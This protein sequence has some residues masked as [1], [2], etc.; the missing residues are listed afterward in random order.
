MT[1]LIVNTTTQIFNQTKSQTLKQQ[2]GKS[3]LKVHIQ[4]SK[5]YVKDKACYELIK[6]KL[7]DFSDEISDDDEIA[8]VKKNKEKEMSANDELSKPFKAASKCPFTK[9]NTQLHN[10]HT[11]ECHQMQKYTKERVTQRSYQSVADGNSQI[12]YANS[13]DNWDDL[14]EK[15]LNRFGMLKAC[16]KDPT[17]ITK[18][19][20]RANEALP[21]FRER[22][23]AV[24]GNDEASNTLTGEIPNVDCKSSVVQKPDGSWRMCID[25]KNLNSSCPKDYYPLPEIDSKIEAVM[26]YPL[27]CFLDA[28]KGYHQVQMSEE[29]EEKTAF[30]TDQDT[31]CYKKMPFGLKNAGATYQRLVDEAFDKQI[32]QNLKV[33]VDDMVIKSKPRKDRRADVAER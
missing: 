25:F 5:R 30:Y 7:L 9:K 19:V 16:D 1:R 31:F 3:S 29:D 23:D 2:Q 18:I 13:I 20:R 8:I 26:G 6:P 24:E 14:E 28:Y 22:W 10:T 11:T 21:N 15:F 12:A 17:E 33:Y 32:E 27:K 4:L